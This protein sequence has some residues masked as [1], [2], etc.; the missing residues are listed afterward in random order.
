MKIST[1]FGLCIVIIIL[2][3]LICLYIFRFNVVNTNTKEGME[4]QS[5]QYKLS[6]LE[7]DVSDNYMNERLLTL[8]NQGHVM[9]TN[10][11]TDIL[12]KS[13]MNC[14]A[15]AAY[16]PAIRG[17]DCSAGYTYSNK[18]GCLSVCPPHQTFGKGTEGGGA[19]VDE[20]ADLGDDGLAC[21]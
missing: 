20:G 17:C 18:L 2:L 10:L 14:L 19:N 16:N 5:G 1:R 8:D 13:G 11:D 3:L 7:V 9:E 21:V 4:P 6:K 12:H 15:P